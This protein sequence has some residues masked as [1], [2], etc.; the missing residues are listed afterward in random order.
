MGR[1]VFCLMPTGGGKSAVYQLPAWCTPG[2]SVVFSPLIS[3]I[4][5]QVE[6]M[7]IIG[8]NSEFV[9]GGHNNSDLYSKLHNYDT[10]YAENYTEAE[11]NNPEANVKLLYVTPEFFGHAGGL[12][13]ALHSLNERGK[14]DVYYVRYL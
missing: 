12:K 9:S 14:K 7:N 2:V 6:A 4:Q 13:K 8:V 1:D 5:D 11:R 10:S 3:L